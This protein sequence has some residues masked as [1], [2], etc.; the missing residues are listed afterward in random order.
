MVK[1]GFYISL[2]GILTQ[3]TMACVKK[4]EIEIIYE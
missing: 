1:G 4:E 2:L 3:N